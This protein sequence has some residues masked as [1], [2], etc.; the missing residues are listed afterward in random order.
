MR[1]LDLFAYVVSNFDHASAAVLHLD[2]R[3]EILA[4]TDV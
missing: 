1:E 2:T 4:E 3:V